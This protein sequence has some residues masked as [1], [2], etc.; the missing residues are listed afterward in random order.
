MAQESRKTKRVRRLANDPS[1]QTL[2]LQALLNEGGVSKTGLRD[3][4]RRLE[5]SPDLLA[6][7]AGRVHDASESR[8]LLVKQSETLPTTDGREFIW[9][10]CN[11]NLL[12]AMLIN[13]SPALQEVYAVIANKM[14]DDPLSLVVTFDEYVPGSK[15]NQQTNR[16]SMNL[17]FNF[18]EVGPEVLSHDMTWFLPISVRTMEVNKVV[19]GWS[20]MLKIFL[21]CALYSPDGLATAGVPL[22]LLGQPYLLRAKLKLLLTDGGAWPLALQWSGAGSIKP[23]FKH[24]NVLKKNCVLTAKSPGFVEIDCA[25]V[26]M[27]VRQCPNNLYDDVDSVVEVSRLHALDPVRTPNARVT[28][29]QYVTGLKTTSDGLLACPRLRADIDFLKVFYY[30]WPHTFLQEGVLSNELTAFTRACMSKLHVAPSFWHSRLLAGWNF[31]AQHRL[32]QRYLHRLF[33]EYRMPHGDDNPKV[34]ANMGEMLGVYGLIRHIITTDAALQVPEIAQERESFNAVCEVMDVILEAKY[35]RMGLAEAGRRI[36]VLHASYMRKCIAIYGREHVKPKM[37]WVFDIADQLEENEWLQIVFDA[38]TIERW[39][40]R[41]KH[42]AHKVKNTRVF[43]KSVLSCLICEQAAELRE[44]NKMGNGLRG[45]SEQVHGLEIAKCVD[46][47]GMR[48]SSGDVVIRGH[49]VGEI[50]ACAQEGHEFFVIVDEFSDIAQVTQQHRIA[51]LVVAQRCVWFA[52][53]AI[54]A[55]AW[56][57]GGGNAI[58]VVER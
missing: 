3:L 33:D 56:Y 21:H 53:E 19:G 23:C 7:S 40:N 20:R 12:M 35:F 4:L 48:L 24:S 42:H 31:P 47:F 30:D 13:E 17:L 9:E 6:G 11:P 32:K 46:M 28:D 29:L 57:A 51:S 5:N 18:A 41:V 25:N 55:L 37:H 8:W 2:L 15:K 26:D 44:A 49:S 1:E 14:R 45:P 38:F 43:E 52:R 50:V 54:P 22:I 36:R 34:R 27:F 10:F 16:K 39:H 58:I